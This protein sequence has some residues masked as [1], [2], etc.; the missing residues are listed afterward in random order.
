MVDYN[1]LPKYEIAG[2]CLNS[3]V[4]GLPGPLLCFYSKLTEIS[5]NL[6][7]S[8]GG[9]ESYSTDAALKAVPLDQFTLDRFFLFVVT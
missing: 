5:W 7:S 9:N 3:K 4:P 2:I 1:T 8:S 6:H